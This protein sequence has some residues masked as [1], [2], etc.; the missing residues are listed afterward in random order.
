MLQLAYSTDMSVERMKLYVTMLGN[1]NPVTLEQAVAN[2]INKCKFL[3]TIAEIRE[4]CS[5]LSNY[6]NAYEEIPTPQDAWEKT[7][8]CVSTYSYEHGLEHLDGITLQAAKTIWSSFDPRM[9]D[10]YNEASCRSQFIRC[11]EQL[12]EREEKNK[13]LANSIK[14]NHLLLKAREKAQHEKALISAGQKKIEMTNTGNLVEVAR[15]PVDVA[16]VLEESKISD[17]A[18]ALLRQAIGG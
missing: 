17:K 3:P 10:E 15:E 2:L 18:K 14:D 5:A 6:V 1:V 9:G 13:R 4:E 12:A 8:R 7:R 16:K 11:Y